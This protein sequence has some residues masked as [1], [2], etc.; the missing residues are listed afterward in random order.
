MVAKPV[1]GRRSHGV[2]LCKN[3]SELRDHSAR[4]LEESPS[5]MLEEYLSGEEAT[6]TVMPPSAQRP[7]YWAMPVIVR[8]NHID[9]IAP[10]NGTVAII[11]NSRTVSHSEYDVDGSFAK[12]SRQCVTVVQ[13]LG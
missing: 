9:G 11:R 3:E 10:Y 12:L 1:R 6:V 2:K 13:L 5:I 8:F 4:L 7:E